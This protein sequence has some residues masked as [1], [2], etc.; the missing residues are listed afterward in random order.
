MK[1]NYSARFKARHIAPIAAVKQQRPGLQA[2]QQAEVETKRLRRTL[3]FFTIAF[4]VRATTIL[5]IFFGKWFNLAKSDYYDIKE[6]TV[7]QIFLEVGY[8]LQFIVYDILPIGMLL[9]LHH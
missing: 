1:Q 6:N 2:P 4:A 8:I 3:I 7:T 5:L 9:L